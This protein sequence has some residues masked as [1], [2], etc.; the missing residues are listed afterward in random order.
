MSLLVV[1][2]AFSRVCVAEMHYPTIEAN[3]ICVH[4]SHNLMLSLSLRLDC[5]KF[6]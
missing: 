2:R 5:A 6:I 4:F 3:V 1:H